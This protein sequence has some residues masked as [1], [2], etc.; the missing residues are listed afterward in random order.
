MCTA[1]EARGE[2]NV[3]FI[4]SNNNTVCISKSFVVLRLPRLS[5][6][7]GHNQIIHTMVAMLVASYEYFSFIRIL[8]LQCH[9]H[10]FQKNDE[11][12]QQQQNKHMCVIA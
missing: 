7:N 10:K 9:E 11:Q 5:Y 8:S 3:G 6:C 2:R 1:S 4:H 12:Q